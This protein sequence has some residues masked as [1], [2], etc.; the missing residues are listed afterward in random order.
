MRIDL[1]KSDP[2]RVNPYIE[3]MNKLLD[4]VWNENKFAFMNLR[5]YPK[6]TV[7]LN[8][9]LNILIQTNGSFELNK[10]S[11]KFLVSKALINWH[12]C[13]QMNSLL[14]WKEILINDLSS[15]EFQKSL[16]I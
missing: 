7:A 9:N 2:F 13:L 1:R 3:K 5:E 16:R 10:I 6:H 11:I 15:W 4:E 8:F 14:D 12:N